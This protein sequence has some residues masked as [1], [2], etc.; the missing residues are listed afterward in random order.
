MSQTSLNSGEEQTRTE[1]AQENPFSPGDIVEDINDDDD[2][3]AVVVEAPAT[4]ADEHFIHAIQKTVA[5][6]NDSYPESD[7]VVQLIY[8]DGLNDELGKGWTTEG[9]LETY[10]EGDIGAGRTRVYS[11]PESR[12]EMRRSQD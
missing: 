1:D 7:H 2:G 9:V 11:F 5:E 10:R 6:V 8:T 12:L 4:R 3:F